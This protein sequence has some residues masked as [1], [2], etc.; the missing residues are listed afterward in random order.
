VIQVSKKWAAF[1]IQKPTGKPQTL[2]TLSKKNSQHFCQIIV[3]LEL[4][5]R[6]LHAESQHEITFI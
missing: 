3:D 6:T 2:N 1:F 5:D 4:G